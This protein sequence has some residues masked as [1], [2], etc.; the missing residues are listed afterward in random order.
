M[1]KLST[2]GYLKKPHSSAG[3]VPTPVGMKFYVRELMKERELSTVEEVRL[4][5]QVWDEREQAFKCL[6]D[7][8][9]SLSQKTGT[10]AIATMDDGQ[11]FVAGYANILDM[12]EFF[13][14]RI[15]QELLRILDEE[16]FFSDIFAQYPSDHDVHVLV[17]EDL[18][19]LRGP[20][21]FVYTRYET[22]MHAHGEIGVLGPVRLNYP[23]IVPTVRYFADLIHEVAKGW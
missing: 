20:Y 7:V 11:I 10:L 16:N 13:D 2:L 19:R 23:Q 22:P 1:V 12:P 14:I 9:K 3:R 4:K 5:E 21:G 15:T 6:R 18:G 8:V 17:G